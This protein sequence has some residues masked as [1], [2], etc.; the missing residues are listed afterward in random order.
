MKSRLPLV[1]G[2]FLKYSSTSSL[3]ALASASG[4]T[5][6]TTTTPLFLISPWSS[7]IPCSKSPNSTWGI[8]LTPFR[9][10]M[11]FSSLRLLN[12]LFQLST[13]RSSRPRIRSFFRTLNLSGSGSNCF[14]DKEVK[15]SAILPSC[16]TRLATV[17]AWAALGRVPRS[18]MQKIR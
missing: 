13:T 12:S 6:F 16:L 18:M 1:D 9:L 5:F 2:F 4:T 14:P 3:Y 10:M 8:T 17:E 11:A 15:A 7:E